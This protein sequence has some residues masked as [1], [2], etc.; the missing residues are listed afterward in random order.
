MSSDAH[1]ELHVEVFRRKQTLKTPNLESTERP[2][3]QVLRP[4][5]PERSSDTH[6][7]WRKCWTF[8]T[9]TGF[10]SFGFFKRREL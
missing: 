3:N 4:Q 7:E 5:P 9:Q 6:G 8:Q 1:G 2:R 10:V